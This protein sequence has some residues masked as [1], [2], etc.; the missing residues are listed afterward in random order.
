LN[1]KEK[2]KQKGNR[3]CPLLP[4]EAAKHR[5]REQRQNRKRK[6]KRKRKE[7]GFARFYPLK[8]QSSE[9]GLRRPEQ[10]M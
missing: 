2:E 3:L 8:L 1:Q 9:G 7:T 4:A 5:R 10:V 6:R